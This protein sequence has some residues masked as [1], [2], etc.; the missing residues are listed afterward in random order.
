MNGVFSFEQKG[1]S[2]LCTQ[3]MYTTNQADFLHVQTCIPHPWTF[4]F[5][6]AWYDFS[7]RRYMPLSSYSVT[8]VDVHPRPRPNFCHE[9]RL[10]FRPASHFMFHVRTPVTDFP[11]FPINR[12]LEFLNDTAAI[13]PPWIAQELFLNETICCRSCCPS[14]WPT[15]L[16][17]A[18]STCDKR[19]NYLLLSRA[20]LSLLC[21]GL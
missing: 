13:E 9:I 18:Y 19:Y 16:W 5:K 10:S 6:P 15:I 4:P 7:L 11:S 3:S 17:H 8:D 20:W 2:R 21:P 1:V 12:L 14:H